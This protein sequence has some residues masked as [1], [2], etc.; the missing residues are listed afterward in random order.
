[1]PTENQNRLAKSRSPYLKQHETNPVDWWEWC[2]EAFEQAKLRDVPVLLSIGYSSCHWCHV[3]AHESFEDPTIAEL[4]NKGFVNVKVDR[5]E[6]PDVDAFYMQATQSIT[7]QGG[8]P[9]TVFVDHNRKP[10]FA[11]TYFPPTPRHGLPSFAQLLAAVDNAWLTRR[12]SLAASAQEIAD[13]LAAQN[14]RKVAM[15]FDWEEIQTGAI[16]VLTQEFDSRAKG[17]GAFPKFPPHLTM[18]FLLR[19]SAIA[20]QE[21]LFVREIALAMA[22]GG[23]FDQLAG[24]F[25]RYSVDANWQVPHF[26]KMLY[27]NALLIQAYTELLK[28][29]SNPRI[30]QIWTKNID[31][32]LDEMLLPS[33]GFAASL[34]ADTEAGEGAY[35]SFDS[36]ELEQALGDQL[37]A[38]R[39]LFSLSEENFENRFLLGFNLEHQIP[40]EQ[41][42][43]IRKILL[44]IRS[45]RAAPG[46]D[47]K[48]ITSWNCWM[49]S[50]LFK[51]SPL[52]PERG[53]AEIAKRSLSY[54]LNNHFAD[55]CLIRSSLHEQ[56]SSVPATLEDWASLGLALLDAHE[57][58]G[59]AYYF[60]T[61]IECFTAIQERFSENG[62]L[63]DTE[64]SSAL[65]VRLRTLYDSSQPS[66]HAMSAELARRLG[67]MTM[68]EQYT[69]FAEH[70]MSELSSLMRTA[71][72]AVSAALW[73]QA[74]L[75]ATP[76]EIAIIDLPGSQLHLAALTTREDGRVI[77]VGEGWETPL[78]ENRDSAPPMAYVCRH[79]ICQAPTADPQS[80]KKM[81][82]NPAS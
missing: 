73:V 38:A 78:L 7:G 3:M 45:T 32:V 21:P 20:G 40:W 74:A 56:S 70:I 55:G 5:E 80:L 59:S 6:R 14:N 69:S 51:A 39:E 72:R 2:D 15:E 53:L 46:R 31:W 43:E 44:D 36:V 1:M 47:D 41:E 27:D 34:D 68:D 17:F 48:V 57:S 67:L 30:S 23:M 62:L 58:L 76:P 8:W 77:S 29:D 61:A 9:M 75:S 4:M 19:N 16:E 33:G 28:I 54:I 64:K 37:A 12:D 52:A 49:I 66:A 79:F 42:Q 24:G 71:P 65:P 26:E 81:L 22:S 63:F 11:G 50:A 10:F 25:A 82:E 18:L 60:D 13:L 35:Y